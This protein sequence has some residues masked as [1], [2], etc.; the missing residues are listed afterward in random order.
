M[1]FSMAALLRRR[2]L[3][4]LVLV[5][6]ILGATMVYV[7]AA[8]ITTTYR[9]AL[10]TYGTITQSIGM[11]GNLAPVAQADLNFASAGTVQSVDVTVGQSVPA[12]T[13]LAALDPTLLSAQL[14]QAQATLA[15]A[16][17]K[18]AQDQAGPTAQ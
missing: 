1:R 5:A 4:T 11:A 12:G 2:V 3:V 16:D 17:A 14:L 10:V 9:T 15:T 18:L 13:T 6:A 7:Q 8:R